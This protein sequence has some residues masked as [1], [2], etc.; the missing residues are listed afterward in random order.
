[1]IVNSNSSQTTALVD[2]DKFP[3]WDLKQY[4]PVFR[5][6]WGHFLAQMR[7]DLGFQLIVRDSQVEHLEAGRGVYLVFSNFNKKIGVGDFLGLIPG[8]VFSS[9][10]DFK[11]S[12]LKKLK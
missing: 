6:L 7:Y 5:S 9:V 2:P 1:M 12:Y 4:S 10:D 3:I 8:K 11:K